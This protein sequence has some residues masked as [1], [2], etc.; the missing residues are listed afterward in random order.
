MTALDSELVLE[1]LAK[2]QRITRSNVVQAFA[3]ETEY[4]IALRGLR[5]QGGRLVMSREERVD[6][7]CLIELGFSWTDSL[8]LY[9]DA[10]DRIAEDEYERAEG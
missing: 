6:R 4:R 10:A 5:P 3:A 2:V 7:R 9:P 1:H 8:L